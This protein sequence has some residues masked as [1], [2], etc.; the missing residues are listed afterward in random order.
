[1]TIEYLKP[2]AQAKCNHIWLWMR[3]TQNRSDGLF[4]QAA[5]VYAMCYDCRF[6]PLWWLLLFNV[7]IW[8]LMRYLWSIKL[9]ASK[10]C[11]VCMKCCFYFT[12]E[13]GCQ[14]WWLMATSVQQAIQYSIQNKWK[15]TTTTINTREF[16]ILQKVSIIWLNGDYHLLIDF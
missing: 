15:K 14:I 2:Y 7:C 3:Y 13:F 9:W 5:K 11:V 1:M 12:R 10:M 4:H 8:N 16:H 6:V